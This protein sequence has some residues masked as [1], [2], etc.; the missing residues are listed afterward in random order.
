MR[1]VSGRPRFSPSSYIIKPPEPR[2]VNRPVREVVRRS[3]A[4]FLFS[5]GVQ[6]ADR[7]SPHALAHELIWSGQDVGAV[8]DSK[9]PEQRREFAVACLGQRDENVVAWTSHLFSDLYHS[10]MGVDCETFLRMVGTMVL[11]QRAKISKSYCLIRLLELVEDWVCAR[12]FTRMIDGLKVARDS[13]VVPIILSE[14]STTVSRQE[15]VFRSLSQ[16][17]PEFEDHRFPP[18]D[19]EKLEFTPAVKPPLNVEHWTISYITCQSPLQADVFSSFL[20]NSRYISVLTGSESGQTNE[21]D[22]AYE[23]EVINYFMSTTCV[24]DLQ[25]KL[26]NFKKA[27]ALLTSGMF[28]LFNRFPRYL[29]FSIHLMFDKASRRKIMNMMKDH[30]EVAAPI[31]ARTIKTAIDKIEEEMPKCLLFLKAS[32]YFLTSKAY[33]GC[34]DKGLVLA[35]QQLGSKDLIKVP[36][37]GLEMWF[38]RFLKALASTTYPNCQ[39]MQLFFDLMDNLETELFMMR[40]FAGALLLIP[41]MVNIF[42][43]IDESIDTRTPDELCL[44]A[45]DRFTTK[46][47]EKIVCLARN[48]ADEFLQ[49]EAPLSLRMFF[50]YAHS[51]TLPRKEMSP[52]TLSFSNHLGCTLMKEI[53]TFFSLISS[54]QFNGDF[55]ALCDL[56]YDKVQHAEIDYLP[57]A[58]QILQGR[59]ICRISRHDDHY[60][61][62]VLHSRHQH[63]LSSHYTYCSEPVSPPA[64]P[65]P[66]VP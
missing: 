13:H 22:L 66:P 15:T 10:S 33:L 50:D 56:Y 52:Q 5:A 64:S 32:N 36:T 51:F 54:L 12:Y 4:S 20:F 59:D 57:E 3:P 28:P 8:I 58:T 1:C 34:A 42:K 26:L 62:E 25:V 23:N 14:E 55:I 30:Y 2:K 17:I 21:E 16:D 38:Y 41:H 49:S 31:M 48:P 18:D 43:Q 35:Q 53:T 7:V 19:R 44:R 27:Y 61:I 63:T 9:V 46:V 40:P 39:H 65:P 37:T 6:L 11:A 47:A 60:A 29:V 24:P 45:R